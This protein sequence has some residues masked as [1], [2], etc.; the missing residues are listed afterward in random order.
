MDSPLLASRL[1]G[2]GV[3]IGHYLFNFSR[4]GAA[5]GKSLREQAAE[6]LRVKMWGIGGKAPNRRSLAPGDNVLIYVGAPEYEFIGN[7]VIGSGAHEWTTEEAARYPGNMESGVLFSEAEAW[8]HPVPMKTVLPSLRLT[9]SNPGARF[10]SG[11]IRITKEDY[12]TVAALGAGHVPPATPWR[13]RESAGLATESP[14]V[15][16]WRTDRPRLAF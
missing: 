14:P 13:P 4:K 15:D 5:K 12:E 6:L 10:F 8:S 7:A 9:E 1:T 3:S 16:R 11:V 2:G